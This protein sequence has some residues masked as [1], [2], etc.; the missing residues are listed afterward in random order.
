MTLSR[1]LILLLVAASPLLADDAHR[2]NQFI[3]LQDFSHF[4]KSPGLTSN[5]CVL[6]SPPIETR[7]DFDELVASWNAELR[8][9]DYLTIEVQAIY[10]EFETRF[11]TMGLWSTDPKRHPRES[12]RQQEDSDGDV[13][14]DILKLKRKAN[15]IQIRLTLGGDGA[16]LPAVKFVGIC[17]TD[18]TAH[19][20]VLAP[21][22]AAWTKTVPAPERSQMAYPNGGVLCSPT[23]VSMIMTYW[24]RQLNRPEL[25]RDVPEI[26]SQ[27]HD[28]NW[29]GTGNWAFNTAYA[30]SYP[31]MRAYVTRLSDVSELEAWIARGVPVGLSVCYNKLRGRPGRPSGHLIVCVGFTDKGDVIVNDP[32]TRQ[33]VRK[34]FPRENLIAGWG[35]SRNTVYLI[36]PETV[37]VPKDRFGHWASR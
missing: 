20:Q 14:T 16:H 21:W 24:A 9:T 19:P 18:T 13:D 3:G 10:P 1:A 22:R 8:E 27:V 29:K 15:R 30:G 33:N 23:T 4:E 2:G 26:V 12:V 25:D 36:Y 17:M 32:G 35:H 11:Y 31:G 37:V 7:V 5:E 34:T 28:P 6:T